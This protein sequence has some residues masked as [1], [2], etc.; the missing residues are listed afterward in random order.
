MEITFNS[1]LELYNRI[2]PALS[3]KREE[4]KRDGVTYATNEDIWNY[5]KEKKWI[6]SKNLSIY[7]ITSD[8][9]GIDNT[10]IDE[11]LKGKM[12]KRNRNLYFDD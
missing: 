2:K 5:L 6:Y 10:D 12:K 7:Q 11:Y 1:E 3:S 9:F 4:L 8:I